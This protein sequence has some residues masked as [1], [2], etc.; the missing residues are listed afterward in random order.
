[1]QLILVSGVSG[2]GKSVA[3]KALEDSGFFC[4]DNLPLGLIRALV[5]DLSSRGE[6]RVA[7]SA[8]ARNATT[9]G[10]LPKVVAEERANGVD[11]RLVFLDATDAS[12][13]RRFSETRRPHPLAREGRTLEEAIDEERNLL[14]PIAEMAHR[15]DTSSHTPVQLRRW[16][17]ELLVMDASRLVLCI[18]SFGF[19]SGVPLDAD[20]VFDARFLPNPYYDPQLRSKTG[21]DEEVAEW[22]VSENER[23]VEKFGKVIPAITFVHI[24]VD[25]FRAIQNGPGLD[26]NRNPGMNDME[27]TGQAEGFCAD[28]VKNGTCAYGGQDVPFMKAVTST[29]GMMGMFSAHIH[30]NSWCYKW[31]SDTL[32]GYPVQPE[33]EGLNICFGQRTGYGGN[34]NWE[35]GTRNLLLRQDKL[36][37]G[38]IDTWIRLESGDAVGSVS[39]NATFGQDVYPEVPV[40]KTYCEECKSDLPPPWA[41]PWLTISNRLDSRQT[42]LRLDDGVNHE[43]RNDGKCVQVVKLDELEFCFDA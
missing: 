40:R 10:M 18:E 23:I 1:M 31:T 38:E 43:H 24:P 4:I 15:I 32:P 3:L 42:S 5:A 22:F 12:L 25:A 8:D 9:I 19:K 6:P 41:V 37:K 29:P 33:G 2:S 27:V 17:H 36:A 28:G 7:V 26:P 14:A 20:F 11:V 21:M 30:G 34:G 16:I 35:R 39:L 13:V